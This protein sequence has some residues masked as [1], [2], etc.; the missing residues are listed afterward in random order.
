M[1]KGDDRRFSGGTKPAASPDRVIRVFISSTFRDMQ[2]ERDYLVK[3]VFPELRKMCESRGVTWGEV[4]LRW[5]VTTEQAAEGKVLPICLEEIKRCRPYFIGLLG[6][7]Y[8][9][10][11]DAIPQGIIDS[12]PWLKEH[13]HDKKSVTELEIL[14]GVLRNPDMAS[15]ALFYF[16]DPAYVKS[17]PEEKKADFTTEDT[18]S[19]ERL[20]ALKEKIRASGFPVRENYPDPKALGEL[21]KQDLIEVVDQLYPPGEELDPLDREAME[22]EA[23]AESR[24]KVYI[25][26]QAYFDRLDAHAGSAGDQPLVVLGDSGSGKSALLAN[27]V[28]RYRQAHPD[29][30]VLQHFIGASPCSADWAA[31][32]RRIMGEFNRKLG[33]Q[34]DIPDSPDSLRSAFPNWL[35]MAA[36]KGRVVLVL[37]ALNQ[38]EDRDGARDLLWLP[39][40]MPENVRLIVST[41]PG[42]PLDVIGDR[43]WPT[44]LVEPLKPDERQELIKE[45]LAQ[46]AKTLDPVL[47]ERIAAAPQSANPLYLRVLLDELRLFGV[48]EQL[49]ER[50]GHYL[51]AADSYELYEKVV[52]RWVNDYSGDAHLVGDTLSLI[53]AARRG[54]S[55]SE[56]LGALGSK[57]QP[58]PRAQWSPLF[59]AMGDGLVSRGGL[60][61]FAHDF[62]RTA[63]RDACLPT[64]EQQHQ[65]HSRLADY[66]ERQPGPR[67]T[68]ELPWQLAEAK[69]WRR[70]Q[71]LLTV[72]GF[73][74]AAWHSSEF[75]VKTYWTRIEADSP[76]R[77]LDA[78]LVQTEHP[79][80]EWDKDFL[81]RLAK[82]LAGTG[83][84]GEAMKIWSHLIELS[85]AT[86]DMNNLQAGLINQAEIL[87]EHGDL[88]GSMALSKEGERICRQLGNLKDLSANLCNQ[89]LILLAQGDLDAAIALLK[90][91]EQISRQLGHAG[92][93]SAILG[94]EALI[95]HDRGDLGGAMMLFKEQERTCRQLGNLSSLSSCLGN[96]ALILHARGDLGGAMALYK[97]QERICRQLGDLDGLS[98]TIGNQ[99]LML[100]DRGDLDVA[101]AL[102]KE[103]ERICRQLGYLDG[104]SRA[105][106]NRSA[107]LQD[108]GNLDGAMALIKEAEQICRQLNN[109]AVL[110]V[111]LG[112]QANILYVR[113][114]LDGAMALYKE[115]ERICRQ[116][117]SPNGLQRTLSNQALI[118]AD[119][120]DLDGAMALH[121]EQEQICRK[122]GNLADLSIA[123]VNRAAILQGRGDLDGAMALYKEGEGICRQLD[124]SAFLRPIL[125]GQ[126]DILHA[127]GDLDG[128]MALLKEGERICRQLGNPGPL[129]EVLGRQASILNLRGDPLGAMALYKEGE[130]ICRQMG[131]L[132]ALATTLGKLAWISADRGDLDGAMALHKEEERICRHL[133]NQKDLAVSLSGQSRILHARGDTEG[134][135]ALLRE[136]ERIFRQLGDLAALATT[137]GNESVILAERRDLD[138]AMALLKE[139]EQIYRQLGNPHGLAAI[140]GKQANVLHMR[141]DLDGALA[142]YREE[143]HICGMLG[144]RGGLAT[145]LFN[146]ALLLSRRRCNRREAEAKC[147]K[148]RE[149]YTA[150]GMSV[151]CS[152]V[153]ALQLQ[154]RWGGVLKWL[155]IGLGALGITL[156]LWNPWVWIIGGPLVLVCGFSI[157]FRLSPRIRSVCQSHVGQWIADSRKP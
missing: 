131:D 39:P 16:R 34:Q 10:I 50:I 26:R 130:R 42:R 62:L 71:A 47:V 142:L 83:H 4:D 106:T 108:R 98:H 146:Q 155:P 27:W 103:Q 111:I 28:I 5:G 96:Q 81:D 70:L 63:V 73:F 136:G 6:E 115:E 151:N 82:L 87:K 156:G 132:A 75:D 119:R 94:N 41:L 29:V 150:L 72:P 22:H 139:G 67:R 116:L 145:S 51:K 125:S 65:A 89:A 61:T 46:H 118:L 148:A 40:V 45:Y 133:G 64:E 53:W 2:E 123:L 105:L 43:G 59:L 25:G 154:M 35:H 85:R 126:A 33:I 30:L 58:L 24:A 101:L 104:L 95:L 124:N 20:K 38:L 80:G 121:E 32:L 48:F 8:G 31:M 66:F 78:Y 14:H 157:A 69:A 37:D 12:E 99:A 144:N 107:I 60:L 128:A 152:R 68:D 134:A 120:G 93:L 88:E 7:R 3:F 49:E 92:I 11:P 17:V 147:A 36:A 127:R 44:Y 90:E 143:E 140:L 15:H 79:Q 77:M 19:A 109:P 110:E 91:G 135:V 117:G 18:E 52:A 100:R 149:I 129:A 141:G 56:L 97:E 86:G 122:L 23:Y 153:Q 1:S 55:E 9:W 13:V 113:G 21:V 57:D 112:R 74:L 137:L 76:L 54:L 138:G 84:S 114:D 102:F